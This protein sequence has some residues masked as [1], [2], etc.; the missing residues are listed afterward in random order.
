MLQTQQITRKLKDFGRVKDLYIEAFPKSERAPIA[1][2]FYIARKDTVR[3]NAYYDNDVFVG[4]T[5]TITI[6]DMIYLLYFAVESGLRSKGYG[7]QI[8]S[9]IQELYPNNRIILN[10]EVEDEKADNNADRIRRKSFYLKNGY[11]LTT[12]YFK[13][14]GNIYDVLVSNGICTADDFRYLWKKYMGTLLFTLYRPQI[15]DNV[16]V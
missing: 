7:A 2:L 10:I 16:E 3:F 5:Y 9:F 4:F 14:N 15:R 13:M 12:I 8:L 1:Y 11:T 6:D